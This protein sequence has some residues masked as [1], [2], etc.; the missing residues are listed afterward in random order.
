MHNF[1]E[2]GVAVVE[3]KCMLKIFIKEKNYFS[4]SVLNNRITSFPYGASDIKNK[5]FPL[6]QQIFASSPTQ[7][8]KESCKKYLIT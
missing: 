8:L 3:F 7:A 2:G 6:P 4:L 1:L 5:P